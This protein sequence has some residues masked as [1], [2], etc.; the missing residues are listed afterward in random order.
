MHFVRTY[1]KVSVSKRFEA[2]DNAEESVE[3]TSNMAEEAEWS[4]E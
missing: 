4:V 3:R 1:S 2:L